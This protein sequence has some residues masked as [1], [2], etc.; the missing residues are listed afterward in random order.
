MKDSYGFSDDEGSDNSIL[1]IVE[2]IEN[3]QSK[4]V[5]VNAGTQQN[6]SKEFTELIQFTNEFVN[7]NLTEQ[8][9]RIERKT[10]CF[11]SRETGCFFV[12]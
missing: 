5:S 6:F 4:F 9:L 2:L 11:N 3:G 10:P 7:A 8:N 1:Y 12:Y